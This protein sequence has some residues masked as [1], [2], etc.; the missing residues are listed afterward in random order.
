M[1]TDQCTQYTFNHPFY[2]GESCE[3]IYNM[4]PES[5]DMSGYYWITDGPTQVYCGMT[6]TG[7][8]CEVI[9]NDYP[10]IR[11]KSGYYRINDNHWTYCDMLAIASCLAGDAGVSG[12]WRRIANI[13]ISAGDVCPSGWRSGNHSDVSFC[14][15]FSDDTGT[16]SSS[17]FSTNG[18]SYQRV[19]GR[20]RG[21]QKGPT[22]GFYAYHR[23]GQGIDGYYADGLS[24]TYGSPRQHVWTYVVGLYDNFTN[25]DFNCPCAGGHQTSPPFVGANYYC[26]SGVIDTYSNSVYYLNDPLWDGSDC[27][28][29]TCCDNPTQPWFYRELSG[30]TTSDIE[31]RICGWHAYWAGAILID[32]LQ[33]YV[34]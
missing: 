9:F 25:V 3:Y 1:A 14:R 6:Y 8:S 34:Q 11:D 17:F 24:V 16:C 2:P 32:Q 31:A 10:E 20:A 26:E 13:D 4:N 29:S 18:T 12:G 33:L 15:R 5:R 19:C 7:S 22:I 30:T 23:H 27:F 21:Y 28:T